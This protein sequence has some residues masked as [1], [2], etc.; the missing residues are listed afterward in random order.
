MFNPMIFQLH[1]VYGEW[2]LRDFR[3]DF[4]V[5]DL[6]GGRLFLL[7]EDST[8]AELVAMAQ[9]DYNLDMRTVS[10]EI[11][12]SLPAEMMMAPGSLPIHVTSDRQVR[13]LL[14]IL[15][16]QRV[17][18]CVSSRSKVGTVS[19]K[20]DIDE[21][22][23]WEKDVGDNDEASEWEEDVGDDDEDV[24]DNEFVEDENQDGEEENG[25]EDAD[26]SIVGETDQNGGDYSLYG[27]VPDEDEEDDDNICFEEIQK[28][29]AKTNAIEGG[30]SNGTSIYV[31]QSFVSKGALLSELR[32]AAVRGKFSFRLY[33]STKTLVVATC[34]VSYCGWKVRASVKHGTN[35]FWVTKYVEKHL[36]S[37][38]DRI[39]QRR[40]CTPKYVG[41]LFIDR[42]GI[43]DGI[44]PQHI[45][46]AMR[47]MFGM[48]LD[49]T[50]SYRALLYA[51]RLCPE[52]PSDAANTHTDNGVAPMQRTESLTARRSP[53]REFREHIMPQNRPF[54]QRYDRHGRPFAN[55]ISA[56][57]NE[58]REHAYYSPPYSRRHLH[59]NG[60]EHQQEDRDNRRNSSRIQWKAKSTLA[61]QEATSQRRSSHSPRPSLGRNLDR[62]DFP[63]LN[64]GIAN[65]TT[66]G[67]T[68]SRSSHPQWRTK[69]SVPDHEATAQRSQKGASRQHSEQVLVA[70]NVLTP[71]NIPSREKVMEELREV[72]LQYLNVDDPT[73]R[74]ARQQR[75]LQSELDGTVEETAANIIQASTNAALAPTR[76]LPLFLRQQVPVMGV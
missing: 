41:S 64:E 66:V 2:L 74:A 48:A 59:Q 33:K 60:G 26:N 55:E 56:P 63:P 16:T 32:L 54:Q 11:S 52:K 53:L 34:R 9:E 39:A 35:T 1:A 68:N 20:R 57:P 45:T 46:D 58:Q 70:N 10:V 36:C 43:I 23:E 38:G 71:P 67:A 76:I 7:N 19:E 37:A 15:K 49:Y 13:N 62:T 27:K 65:T 73:E 25:E 50:T 29:Y 17:C 40:H 69:Q 4:V 21:A 5:D 42:V 61:D 8:H 14:E 47:N 28:T 72:T 24:G 12:Y 44:T 30:K 22:G 6:K 51:Q 31:N 75:V 18:L 3:W